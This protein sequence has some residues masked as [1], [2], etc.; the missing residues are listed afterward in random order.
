MRRYANLMPI[1]VTLLGLAFFGVMDGVMKSASIAVG[2]YAAMFWRGLIG[3]AIMAP[4]WWRQ[5]RRAG[6]TGWPSQDVMR[7]HV[8]RGFV[9]VVMAV[10]FFF[11]LVRTPMAEAMALTFIAP[12]IALYL[13]ALL[14]GEKV[15]RRAVGGSLLALMGVGVIAAGKLGGNYTRD[16][17]VG[18]IAILL[19]A[20]LYAWNLVLQRRQ[21]QM[22]APEEI[23]FFQAAFGFLFLA[24]GAVFLAPWPNLATWGVIA[25]AAVLAMGSLMLLGWAYARAEA[26]VLVPL[27]YSAF[28]WA[29]LVGWVAFS[30]PVTLRTLCG[31]ALIVAGCLFATRSQAP[32]LEPV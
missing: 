13:A 6:V 27:E 20:V 29:A 25:A 2:P 7:V 22:A 16:G 21:A 12:L 23:A 17:V 10:T 26:Q 28:V 31:V 14:L 3:T 24:P 18:L 4:L 19:S 32:H 9:A 1:L 5:R 30:E 8:L 15:S 11:G